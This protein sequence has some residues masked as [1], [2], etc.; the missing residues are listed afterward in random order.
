MCREWMSKCGESTKPLPAIEGPAYGRQRV[1]DLRWRLE[2]IGGLR[3]IGRSGVHTQFYVMTDQYIKDIQM[4][5]RE[6]IMN[7]VKE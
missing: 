1:E 7:I 3:I 4:I 6:G 2:Y 5:L